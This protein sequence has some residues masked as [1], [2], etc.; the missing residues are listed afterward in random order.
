MRLSLTGGVLVLLA[1]MSNFALD[2]SAT[3]IYTRQPDQLSRDAEIVVQGHVRGQRSY[4][5]DART[6]ILT[7]VTVEVD[8]SYKGGAPSTVRVLQM[9][10]ELD[11]VRMT[12]HGATSWENG[13]EVLLFLEPSLRQSYRLSGFSQGKFEVER[14]PASGAVY[15]TRP[16]LAGTTSVNGRSTARSLRLPLRT[17][18]EQA[19]LT[20][21][22][23]R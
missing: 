16:V 13:A 1:L 15:A 17:L 7:E 20:E 9:G 4:W 19:D 3:Q 10:G 22:E 23:V 6:R 21:E 12:V 11:G 5:N 18:L 8:Q 14:D 2:A